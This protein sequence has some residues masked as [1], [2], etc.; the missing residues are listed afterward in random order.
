MTN[1]DTCCDGVIDMAGGVI[2]GHVRSILSISL[3]PHPNV[4]EMDEKVFLRA[5]P[6]YYGSSE[7]LIFY[8][9]MF[10][11]AIILN[12]FGAFFL[13]LH[14]SFHLPSPLWEAKIVVNCVN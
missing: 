2:M 5:N 8:D 10:I 12:N 11:Y 1:D 4:K 7:A 13:A 6:I 14:Y 9:Q 3:L